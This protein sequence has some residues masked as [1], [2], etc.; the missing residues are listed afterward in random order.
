MAS[1]S[2]AIKFVVMALLVVCALYAVQ[3]TAAD[4][5]IRRWQ[6][7]SPCEAMHSSPPKKDLH[8][9]TSA[10]L[11]VSQCVA[12]THSLAA[13]AGEGRKLLQ[14]NMT[15]CGYIQ[16]CPGNGFWHCFKKSNPAFNFCRFGARFPTVLTA[17]T[18][19]SV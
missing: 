9:C 12:M 13:H 1:R 2:S 8:S 11:A 3:A 5:G 15:L 6:S 18:K 17:P 19:T 7:A 14:S 10:Q 4:T 16:P